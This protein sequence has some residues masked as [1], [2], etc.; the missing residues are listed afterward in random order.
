[1]WY[2]GV[3]CRGQSIGLG[4]PGI[5][6]FYWGR[7]YSN[8]SGRLCWPEHQDLSWPSSAW[9]NHGWGAGVWWR[10][11]LGHQT[12]SCEQGTFRLCHGCNTV[13]EYD[14]NPI[15]EYL[16]GFASNWNGQTSGVMCYRRGYGKSHGRGYCLGCSGGMIVCLETSSYTYLA[17]LHNFFHCWQFKIL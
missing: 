7:V 17:K 10:R 3:G 8:C 16:W 12:L 14:I 6:F 4:G 2:P 13:G 15:L 11:L 9:F 5:I 1:M